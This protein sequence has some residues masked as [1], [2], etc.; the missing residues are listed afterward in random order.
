[1]KKFLIAAALFFAAFAPGAHAA[2]MP[3]LPQ[4]I[5]APQMP[6]VEFGSNWY[7]RGDFSYR[8]YDSPSV[9][10]GTQALTNT[11]LKDAAAFGLGVGYKFNDWLR[12]DITY[13]YAFKSTF[14]GNN[15]CADPCG[16]PG[17]GG[18]TNDT[19]NLRSMTLLVNGYVD[20][21][22]WWG[23]TP[24]VGAGVGAAYLSTG[25]YQTTTPLNV[26]TAFPGGSVWNFAWNATAGAAYHV[27]PNLSFDFNYRY[28][29]LGGFQANPYS[30][31]NITAHE[32]R[33]GFRYLID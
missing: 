20:M 5:R 12:G 23:I 24:Y 2:D 19:T 13:D 3:E 29:D 8:Q 33:V 15:T 16:G 31:D 22:T 1:M 21:G 6:W 26:V 9:T 32:F 7:L 30:S 11:S 4:I 27:S 18:I 28:L 14:R 17:L 25:G 10:D